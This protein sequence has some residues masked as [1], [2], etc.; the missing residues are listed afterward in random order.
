M[1]AI[2]ETDVAAGRLGNV[3]SVT[4]A[5]LDKALGGRP[6]DEVEALHLL[7]SRWPVTYAT[8]ARDAR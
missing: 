1:R 6:I 2:L 7:R 8:A 4:A 5:T 3:D